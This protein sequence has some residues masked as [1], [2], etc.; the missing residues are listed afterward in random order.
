M[1]ENYLQMKKTKTTIIRRKDREK[2][3]IKKQRNNEN[4]D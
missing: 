3:E 4:V 1:H 2:R